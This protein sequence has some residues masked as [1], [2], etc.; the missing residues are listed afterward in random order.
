MSRTKA[1]VIKAEQQLEYL[2]L[3]D[4]LTDL[5]N[6]RAFYDELA[7]CLRPT[8]GMLPRITLHLLDLDDFKTVNDTLGHSA[9]DKLLRAIA[10]T[11]RDA[12]R[13]PDVVSRI[14][15]DE[16][17]IVSVGA[18]DA[19]QS[20]EVAEEVIRRL[21]RTFNLEGRV[22][23][24]T[25]SIGFSRFPDDAR[26][27][28]SLVSSADIALYAAKSGG[29]N[30]AIQFRPEMTAEA[31]RRATLERD[32]REALDNHGLDIAYQPQFECRT[33][34][35][36]GVE[37][38]A[39]W[40][41]PVQGEISPGEFVPVAENSELI[42]SLGRWV[43]SRAC[44]DA[45]RW[46]AD[47]ATPIS[48]AVNV[49]ARQ[50]R[51]QNFRAHVLDAL[52]SSGLRP[53]LLELELTESLLMENVDVAVDAMKMLRAHGVRLSI[54]D[55][56]TGYSSLSYLQSFPLNQLKIDRSFV[57]PLPHSG[58]PIVTAIISMAH[59]FGLTVVAEGVE[60]PAQ[61][62][63]LCEGGC[64]F[65]QGYLTGR[66]MNFQG[67]ADALAGER[68]QTFKFER[69]ALKSHVENDHAV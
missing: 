42:V 13:A 18:L 59:S 65:V 43:L 34:R 56:G 41:H 28:A 30:L 64:D 16:F 35:L 15:G 46:N 54:D 19:A 11:L 69:G 47:A 51:H 6:R 45:A 44:L 21:A 50:L 66:P 36:V 7:R 55:F 53:A 58:Q 3:T 23:S 10:E 17:A 52:Q 31:Q 48:V 8:A 60:Y 4:P 9:G 68:E 37:A 62:A 1:R 38:L 20:Q 57:K 12:I 22:V 61:L 49:S 40:K 39:R 29:K 67:V 33:G 5:P 2:A 24:A 63:W 27:I 14:G 26:D 25:V 32:L